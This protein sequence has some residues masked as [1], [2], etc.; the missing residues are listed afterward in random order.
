MINI[1]DA[2]SLTSTAQVPTSQE[3][4]QS[5]DQQLNLKKTQT[6]E[7]QCFLRIQRIPVAGPAGGG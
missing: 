2:S 7:M 4:A 6:E 3:L 1:N 5:S